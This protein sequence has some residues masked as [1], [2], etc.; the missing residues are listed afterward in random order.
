[1]D[2]VDWCLTEDKDNIAQ[3]EPVR[4]YKS[5]RFRELD[6]NVSYSE[7]VILLTDC[8]TCH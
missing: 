4:R 8:S 5:Y 1:M 2:F 6:I 3:L 7:L